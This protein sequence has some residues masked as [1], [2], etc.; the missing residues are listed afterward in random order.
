MKVNEYV[1][2]LGGNVTLL[3]LTRVYEIYITNA[4]TQKINTLNIWMFLCDEKI[5]KNLFYFTQ[6]SSLNRN[7]M[8][9]VSGIDRRYDVDVIDICYIRIWWKVEGT[10][11]VLRSASPD[12]GL[13]TP[14]LIQNVVLLWLVGEST[15]WS[16]KW[17]ASCVP[18]DTSIIG[19]VLRRFIFPFIFFNIVA[20]GGVFV[21]HQGKHN[22][23]FNIQT[24]VTQTSSNQHRGYWAT[25]AAG[26]TLWY[27]RHRTM[28]TTRVL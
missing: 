25:Q 17:T 18:G 21:G 16:G 19:S 27:S 13:R 15:F 26:D 4:T 6:L 5:R 3:K 24:I 28:R 23:H 20:W 11:C 12:Q 1:S 14:S 10:F 9:L 8:I 2:P 7:Q 22:N